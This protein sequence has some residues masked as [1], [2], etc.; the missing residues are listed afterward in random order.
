MIN[1]ERAILH[2]GD[3]HSLLPVISQ[4]ELDL[5]DERIHKYVTK[6]IEKLLNDPKVKKG[7][8]QFNSIFVEEMKRYKK[9]SVDFT[10]M[11]ADIATKY[12]EY[13]FESDE[14]NNVDIL[15]VEFDYN[16]ENLLGVIELK[17]IQAYTHRVNN[18]NDLVSNEIIQHHAILPNI[19]QKLKSFAFVNTN[20]NS[21]IFI[22][23]SRFLNGQDIFIL[24]DYIL[25]CSDSVSVKETLDAIKSIA[26]KISEESGENSAK[27]LAKTKNMILENSEISDELNIE[28]LGELVF[29]QSDDLVQK[30][31]EAIKEHGIKGNV[32]IEKSYAERTNKNHKIKTDT[33]ISITIPVEYYQD[34]DFVEFNNNPDGT[35]SISLKKIGQIINQ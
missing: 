34:S 14:E 5:R 23:N 31:S 19:N 30:Y 1:V 4:K 7:E 22:D 12:L 16:G 13:I 15:F 33:G 32:S 3:V 21:I 9:N 17:S 6:H 27:I 28:E 8:F 20:T 25:K 35:I 29:E 24:K 2:I 11:S 10:G 18:D 26:V